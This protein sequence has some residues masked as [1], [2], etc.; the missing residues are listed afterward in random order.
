MSHEALALL[1]PHAAHIAALVANGR[2]PEALKA[3]GDVL[4][5]LTAWAVIDA[6]LSLIDEEQRQAAHLALAQRLGEMEAAQSLALIDSEL[7][8]PDGL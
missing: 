2:Q 7:D 6:T 3:A 5:V 1:A 4:P 8:D